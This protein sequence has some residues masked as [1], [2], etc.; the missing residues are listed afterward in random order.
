MTEIISLNTTLIQG[1]GLIV[2][3]A[4]LK[5]IIDPKLDTSRVESYSAMGA[6]SASLSDAQGEAIKKV[7]ELAKIK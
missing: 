3:K 4:T 1:V 5:V 7:K 6:H 2:V